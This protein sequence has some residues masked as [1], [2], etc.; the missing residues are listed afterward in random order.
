M[1]TLPLC[2]PTLTPFDALQTKFGRITE[3]GEEMVFTELA[4]C[5]GGYDLTALYACIFAHT[6]NKSCK[7]SHRGEGMF[8][9]DYNSLTQ[10]AGLQKSR[11][12]AAGRMFIKAVTRKDTK[13]QFC[14]TA[15]F[16]GNHS[17]FSQNPMQRPLKINL[18]GLQKD[19]L[20]VGCPSCHPINSV[21]ALKG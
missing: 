20:R 2:R 12:S 7:I 14:L 8:L 17:S 11:F 16:S 21:K 18:W 4:T 15:Y 19:F 1:C 6:V 5:R 10:G 3:Y 9:G 13:L